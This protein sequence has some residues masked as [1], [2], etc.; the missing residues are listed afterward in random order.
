MSDYLNEPTNSSTTKPR[1]DS[2]SNDNTSVNQLLNSTTTNNPYNTIATK[3][4]ASDDLPD[5][6]D[7]LK[8]DLL[9]TGQW[10]ALVRDV[11][12]GVTNRLEQN[13]IQFFSDLSAQEKSLFIDEVEKSLFSTPTY[14]KFQGMLSRSLDHS[15]SDAVSDDV[16]SD[17]GRKDLL[18]DGLLASGKTDSEIREIRKRKDH[19]TNMFRNQRSNNGVGHKVDQILIRASEGAVQL[20]KRL[21]NEKST[22]RIMLNKQFPPKLR[23]QAWRLYLGHPEARE[24]YEK[25]VIVS[26]MSTISDQDSEISL[27]CQSMLD[28]QAYQQ[29]MMVSI[30]LKRTL[31]RKM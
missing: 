8:T 14:K 26:R 16:L 24:K 19:E 15:L 18:D 30:N 22:L 6:L 23:Y 31:F 25:A 29:D 5:W 17:L 20:L 7:Q 1:S 27:K 13:H 10:G 12:N 9:S 11:Y 2:I 28:E 3:T 21:P 4:K